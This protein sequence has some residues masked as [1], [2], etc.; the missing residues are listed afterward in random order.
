MSDKPLLLMVDANVWIDL[1][2][3]GRPLREDALAFFDATQGPEV[4]LAFTLEIARAV[5]R[6]VAHEAKRWV[7]ASKGVLS[8]AYAR[9]IAAHAWDFVEDMQKYGTAVGSG[10]ADLW[11]ASKLRDEHSE[12][13]DDLI[14]AACMRLRSDYLVTNDATLIAHAPVAAVTPAQML[15]LLALHGQA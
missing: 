3:P 12:I 15:K 13:E 6:V 5:Y 9:A 8:E 2:V 1:Y 11:L 4:E 7:R 14:V 10:T